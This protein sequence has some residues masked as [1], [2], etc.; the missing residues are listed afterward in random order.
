MFVKTT[1]WPRAAK[2]ALVAVAIAGLAGS[3]ASAGANTDAYTQALIQGYRHGGSPVRAPKTTTAPDRSDHPSSPPVKAPAEAPV[4]PPAGA[5]QRDPAQARAIDCLT[6][7]VY[8]EARGEQSAGQAAVAQV[9]LNRTHR[10]GY[11]KSVCGV[12]YERAGGRDCQFS[13]VC[14]GAMRRTRERAAWVRSRQVAVRALGGHVMKAVGRATCF[15]SLPRQEA[16]AEGV[17]LGHQV[18]YAAK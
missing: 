7:A 6:A 17:R 14:N 11:P 5:R 9:V 13:F 1:L 2:R 3:A 8:Y 10:A 15:H 12:V 18:F 4:K 16:S